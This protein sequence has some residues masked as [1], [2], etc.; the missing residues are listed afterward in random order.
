MPGSFEPVIIGIRESSPEQ[1]AEVLAVVDQERKG[2]EVD[3]YLR[4][5]EQRSAEVRLTE[6]GLKEKTVRKHQGNVSFYI[7]HYLLRRDFEAW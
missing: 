3:D 2:Y 6:S 1:K 5:R 7:D 4:T